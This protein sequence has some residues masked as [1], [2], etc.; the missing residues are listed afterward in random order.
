[1]TAKEF[2]KQWYS[3]TEDDFVSEIDETNDVRHVIIE[4]MEAYVKQLS[5]MA[6]IEY[7]KNRCEAAEKVIDDYILNPPVGSLRHLVTFAKW[8]DIKVKKSL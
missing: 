3:M 8:K 2:Y 6:E 1:M 7:W 4:M 5:G